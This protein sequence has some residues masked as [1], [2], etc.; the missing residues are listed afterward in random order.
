MYNALAGLLVLR[1]P[2]LGWFLFVFLFLA[3]LLYVF[4]FICLC[5]LPQGMTAYY[6]SIF[7]YSRFVLIGLF[8]LLSSP[9]LAE[10]LGVYQT[11]SFWVLDENLF[12]FIYWVWVLEVWFVLSYGVCLGRRCGFAHFVWPYAVA[13]FLQI[14]YECK[15]PLL[16]IVSYSHQSLTERV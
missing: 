3:L 8:Y 1:Q 15:G 4:L 16:W 11:K 9:L 2:S 5:V 10:C 7:H 12:W 13:F 6:S 14:L